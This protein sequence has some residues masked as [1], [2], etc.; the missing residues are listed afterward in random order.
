LVTDAFSKTNLAM[1]TVHRAFDTTL[2]R[3][4]A[5]KLVTYCEIEIEGR[6][7]REIHRVVVTP[8]SIKPQH[9]TVIT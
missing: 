6:A 7:R 5:L 2:E 3:E 9:S 4:I 8:F 1:G